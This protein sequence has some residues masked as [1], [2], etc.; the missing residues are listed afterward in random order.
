MRRDDGKLIRE[1]DWAQKQTHAGAA[2]ALA[3]VGHVGIETLAIAGRF[4][5]GRQFQAPSSDTRGTIEAGIGGPCQAYQSTQRHRG[6][7]PSP[8]SGIGGQRQA[9]AERGAKRLG[10]PEW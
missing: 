8:A 3:L 4:G 9:P 1:R 5:S 6:L 7:E 2:A 10:T